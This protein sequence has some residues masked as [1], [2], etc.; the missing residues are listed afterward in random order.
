MSNIRDDYEDLINME[1]L[2]NDA[3]LGRS[4]QHQNYDVEDDEDFVTSKEIAKMEEVRRRENDGLTPARG[5]VEIEEMMQFKRYSKVREHKYTESEMNAIIESCRNTIVHDY[6]QNDYYHL[7]DEE[8]ARIDSLNEIRVKLGAIK[9]IHHN[10][11][12]YVKDMRIVMEA[13]NILEKNDNFLHSEDE[14]F[15]MV[16]KGQIYNSS[17]IM[18][19][20]KGASR[21]NMDELA[22]YIANPELDPNELLTEEQK[23]KMKEGSWFEIDG[24]EKS[25][26]CTLCGECIPYCINEDLEPEFLHDH[27]LEKHPELAS[28][29]EGIE[30]MNMEDQNKI[31]QKY[32]RT[33]EEREMERLL[34]PEEIDVIAD[35]D[36]KDVPTIEAKEVKHSMLK[37]YK[38]SVSIFN[39]SKKKK[40]KKGNKTKEYIRD[41]FHKMLSL[42]ESNPNNLSDDY[43]YNRSYAF[44]N[45]IFDVEKEDK[46]FYDNI[47]FDGSWADDMDVMLY[48]LAVEEAKMREHPDG[49]KYQTYGD[50]QLDNFFKAMEDANLSVLEM[51]RAMNMTEED[52]KNSTVKKERK[53]NKKKEAAVLQRLIKLNGNPKFKKL[54]HKAEKQI[55]EQMKEYE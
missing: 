3:M 39:N 25:Y 38:S 11:A 21:Y 40:H 42:I 51:R 24:E 12:S 13:W 28:E 26:E 16:A 17:I 22:R 20:L 2:I 8:R 55:D 6:G 49:S 31:I 43:E 32:F 5:P 1:S 30:K 29:F 34:T 37:G 7:T 48:D 19:K 35:M 36:M 33:F 23:R 52:L 44:M 41:N 45:S 18:P 47:R 4:Y 53:N 46:S 54:I 10:A 14:F 9:R 27:I 15:K 50:I